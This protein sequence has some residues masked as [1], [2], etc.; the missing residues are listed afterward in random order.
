[1]PTHSSSDGEEMVRETISGEHHSKVGQLSSN[2][3]FAV[4]ILGAAGISPNFI[5]PL[6]PADETTNGEYPTYNIRLC[7][8]SRS[9]GSPS[10]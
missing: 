10:P 3:L 9:I 7:D 6:V 8:V 4:P 5:I 1:M 2:L